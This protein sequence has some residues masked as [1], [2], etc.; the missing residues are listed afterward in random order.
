MKSVSPLLSV[1]DLGG[2]VSEHPVRLLPK[3]GTG[4]LGVF[5][6]GAG[7]AAVVYGVISAI[8][9][10]SQSAGYAIAVTC[11]PALFALVTLALGAWCLF[12]AWNNV[13]SGVAVFDRGFAVAHWEDV[14]SVPWED[15]TA[16]WQAITKHYTNGIYTGTSYKYTVQLVDDTKYKLDNKYKDIEAL[17]KAIQTNVTNALY[18]KYVAALK[19]GS[20]LEFGPIA[21]DYNKI[22]S[23]K[24]ELPWDAV[25]SVRVQGGYLSVKK[26][27]GWFRWSNAG[28]N[29]IPNFF[30]LY[31]LLK[32][33]NLIEQA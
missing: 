2:L 17:G 18:P 5:L 14:R 29:Q 20:R 26:E 15:V 30:I 31:A 13:G 22:Y 9:G 16:V 12:T 24:K 1:F 25:K 4:I 6:T 8:Q 7:I 10:A 27:K 11:I 28:V 23:G 3:W 32:E 19:A 33:F 21:L